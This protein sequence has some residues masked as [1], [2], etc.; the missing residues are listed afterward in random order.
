MDEV[1]TFEPGPYGR[2]VVVTARAKRIADEM[3]RRWLDRRLSPRHP[4]E[5]TP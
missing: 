1:E 5:N 3:Y 4:E 2:A